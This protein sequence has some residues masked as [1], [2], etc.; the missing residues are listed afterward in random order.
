[1]KLD[2]AKQIL[3]KA[4][5]I[6]NETYSNIPFLRLLKDELLQHEF[7]I[8][9]YRPGEGLGKGM[10][11]EKNSKQADIWNTETGVTMEMNDTGKEYQFNV[12]Q[13]TYEKVE[14]IA[15]NIRDIFDGNE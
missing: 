10:T 5:Y 13:V 6:I 9:S 2:E 12:G 7:K 1:M 15:W 8:I 4:G 11:V 3:K 14:D